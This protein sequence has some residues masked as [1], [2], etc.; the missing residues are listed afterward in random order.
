MESIIDLNLKSI[1]YPEKATFLTDTLFR[2]NSTNTAIITGPLGSGK[3]TLLNC[4]SSI[5]PNVEGYRQIKMNGQLKF[6]NFTKNFIQ[7]DKNN[8]RWYLSIISVLFQY[9]DNNFI[10]DTVI[11]EFKLLKK[12]IPKNTNIDPENLIYDLKIRNLGKFSIGELS[13][14][15]KQMV[16]LAST[17][18][19]NPKNVFLDEPLTML[20]KENR[21]LFLKW[22]EKLKTL[23]PNKGLIITTH[24]PHLFKF[25]NPMYYIFDKRNKKFV[26]SNECLSDLKIDGK[27]INTNSIKKIKPYYNS[28]YTSRL[29]KIVS[30]KKVSI[31][32]KKNN[33]IPGL[34]NLNFSVDINQNILLTGLNGTGKTTLAKTI[35]GIHKDFNGEI[36]IFDKNIEETN[37]IKSGDVRM[38]VQIPSNQIIFQSVK[39]EICHSIKNHKE[40]YKNG[41]IL[42]IQPFL[43]SF[44]ITL[45]D[46]PL[47]LSFGQQ[48][49]VCLLSNLNFP[50]LLV[51][52]EPAI[53]LDTIQQ[54]SFC[55]IISFYQTMG[56]STLII[57]H[58][59]DFF[60]RLSN[61]IIT[62]E[63]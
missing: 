61:I 45:E 6:R 7:I 63:N 34:S 25:L 40:S 59:P 38:V 58:E 36:T 29:N 31:W 19:R 46:D 5:I 13:E 49:V 39:D 16:A 54:E 8:Y 2:Y 22:L 28:N 44:G 51:I 11:D 15:Q 42:Q 20:D 12:S 26:L 48:K 23:Y 43:D 9:P 53:S 41:L 55:R 1:S 56:V 57:T 35:C 32:Y 27:K 37:P 18:L 10:A 3:S 4:L 33:P 24:R 17:F 14:G 52:D 47:S 62:L 50:K 60:F 21:I 30:F